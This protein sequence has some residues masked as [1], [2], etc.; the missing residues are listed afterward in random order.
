[1]RNEKLD[2]YT[3][4]ITRMLVIHVYT[5]QLPIITSDDFAKLAY[6]YKVL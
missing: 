6:K 2:N 3:L 4:N 1:M 5:S